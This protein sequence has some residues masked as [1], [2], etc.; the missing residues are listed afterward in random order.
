VSVCYPEEI[1]TV[2]S[3]KVNK[4]REGGERKKIRK[5]S[6]R[7]RTKFLNLISSVDS[8]FLEII[9]PIYYGTQM[10]DLCPRDKQ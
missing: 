6:Y 5:W 7:W 9:D 3:R 10:S 1:I 2:W 4:R 8:V